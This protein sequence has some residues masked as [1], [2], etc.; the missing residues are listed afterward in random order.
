[1]TPYELALTMCQSALGQE[2]RT[3]VLR[4]QRIGEIVGQILD[5]PMFAAG[6]IDRDKL[7]RELETKFQVSVQPMTVL[8]DQRGHK[9]WLEDRRARI[10]WQ[11]W[12]RY[13]T[14]L[15][16]KIPDPVLKE[17]D[18]TTDSVMSK[19]EDPTRDGPWDRRGLVMGHVQSGKTS[20][21]IGVIC[22]AADAGYKVIIVL[23]GMH[24]NLRTQTQI[25]LDEGFVGYATLPI[26]VGARPPVGV[27]TIDPSLRTSVI[28]NRSEG[29][30]FNMAVARNFAV[31]PDSIP[32]L[33]VVKKNASVLKNL[34]EQ[35][36][37][38][39]AGVSRD[40]ETGRPV[41]MDVPLLLID[42][43]ADL[44]SVDT[45]VGA[46]NQAGNV[47]DNHNPT[48]I[49]QRIR[50]LLTAFRK[51]SY[52][53]YTATPF[54]NIFIH[55]QGRTRLLGDDLFPRSFIINLKAPS[56][57][58]G[59]ARVFGL[60]ADP[61]RNQ[62]AKEGLPLVR[63]VRDH[64]DSPLPRERNGWMPPLHD[65]AHRPLVLGEPKVPD[66]L[67]LAILSFLLACAARRQRGQ[68]PEHNSMLVHVTRFTAVQ[69]EVFEQ[70]RETI[71][72]IRRRLRLAS[73]G[74]PEPLVQELQLLWESDF[75]S[76]TASIREATGDTGL[77]AASWQQVSV[78]VRDV[79]E[80][81]LLREVNGSAGD[82]LDYEERKQIGLTVIAIG[83]D[84]L[85][86]G[87]TLEGLTVSYFLRATKMYD[88]LMQMGRWFGYRPDHYDLCR[89]Y[90]TEDLDTW[91]C[92]LAN[93]SEEL[94]EEFD[95]MARVGGTPVD[96]GLKVRSH[97]ALM[98]TSQVKMRHRTTLR[99]SY[100]GAISETT[101]FHR[102]ADTA[103]ANYRATQGFLSG[104]GLP[105]E[106]EP[107]RVR[108]VGKHHSWPGAC[109]WRDVSASAVKAFLR[110]VATHPDATRANGKLL[111]D[112][113]EKQNN[114]PWNRD[115]EG[116]IEPPPA[117]LPGLTSWTV[118]LMSGR[119]TSA[120]APDLPGNISVP[121][122]C[123]ERKWKSSDLADGSKF[124]IR[125]LLSPKDEGIDLDATAYAAAMAEW[126]LGQDPLAEP[127]DPLPG[128]FMRSQRDKSNGLL[129]L[130]LLDWNDAVTGKD[131]A[132]GGVPIVGIG[133]SFPGGLRGGEIRYEV[134]NIYY[135]QE[136]GTQDD[137][138]D[139]E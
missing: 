105:T 64:A 38:F 25:R 24:N 30:D 27:G 10:N 12:N 40:E 73:G 103:K 32:L 107:D 47:D 130:Y 120:E 109:V 104:L 9:P 43:E 16:R 11:F 19:L 54:A 116:N 99:I 33:F 23:A 136:F 7:V 121:I 13:H 17:I 125:R 2:D 55:D 108:P 28:T 21:Y 34:V 22:K 1:M 31:N 85:A 77:P 123:N 51:S 53:G 102:D 111:A 18:R 26:T 84:K 5:M 94:R 6:A 114:K 15:T 106:T 112:Y 36:V 97:P 3:L 90:M 80:A 57:Y 35:W 63:H 126:R 44:A 50:E 39:V 49:N 129:L 88:T 4:R 48:K 60:D 113:I 135:R 45:K 132:K 71:E 69:H 134:N 59:P 82:I 58:L 72:D 93:A 131:R 56:D 100:S 68:H 66:S 70:V 127:P 76:T 138:G 46:V 110:T 122:H 75:V 95:H 87:L 118:A 20:N 79:A 78:F 65:S 119:N 91:Y 52:L 98:V 86:R 67:R 81:V 37:P 133:V 74:T 62:P 41:I 101:V 29:G 61:D 92:H 42:D 117:G 89:L 139:A 14:F 115:D 96:Y 124:V 128:P 8:E 83:G 137:T